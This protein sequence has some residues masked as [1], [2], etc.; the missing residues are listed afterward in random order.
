M[1]WYDVKLATLQKMFSATGST[2]VVDEATTEYIAGMPQACN[3]ALQMLS[4]AGK[5]IIKKIEIANNP[6]D[7][8]V[9]EYTSKTITQ[10]LEPTKF[11]TTSGKAYT[12][13]YTGQGLLSITV[14]STTVQI[15][16]PKTTFYENYKGLITNTLDEEVTFL[17]T[18][19]YP[20][21]LKDFGVYDVSFENA[22]SVPIFEEKIKYDLTTVVD[23]FYQL[24]SGQVYFEGSELDTRYIKTNRFF[25]E[26]N[27][28]LVI[29]RKIAGNYVIYYKAY[30]PAITMSTLDGYV[31]PLD[32]EVSVLLP[33]YMASQLYK[34]DNASDATTYRNEFEVAFSRLSQK[35]NVPV[36][37][38]LTSESGWI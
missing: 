16:L 32:R 3:E 26:G 28:V 19:T 7:N 35:A 4:T 5:F 14:G 8:L 9:D 13:S 22:T 34:D 6:I 15:T 38:M 24:E 23:D 33:L 2:I 21:A 11:V 1:T 20:S 29:D 17:F 30:P 37:E 31:L 18:P 27:T 10:L 12:F 36:A 25:Q